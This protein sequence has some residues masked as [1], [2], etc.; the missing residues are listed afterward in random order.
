MTNSELTEVVIRSCM[1]RLL[2]S[3]RHSCRI[4]RVNSLEKTLEWSA[5][6]GVE[7]MKPKGF[8]R[9]VKY[10]LCI[11]VGRPTADMSEALRFGKISLLPAQLLC[12]QLLLGHIHC[13][14]DK[15]FEKPLFNNGK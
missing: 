14:T 8:I 3:G 13:R 12:E 10:L 6:L 9:Y 7:A 4:F 15:T 5:V 11:E 1:D 2:K